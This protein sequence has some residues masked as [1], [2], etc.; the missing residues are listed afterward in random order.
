MKLDIDENLITYRSP[1]KPA[2]Q[3]VK[4]FGDRKKCPEAPALLL[5]TLRT[6]ARMTQADVAKAIGVERTSVV[7]MEA[8]NQVVR[9]E[10]LD[11]LADFLGVEL[12]LTIAPKKT[13]NADVTGLAPRKD[14]K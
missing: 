10:Y 1:I 11:K 9:F 2:P 7:N 13:P 3:R 8:L 5:R 4:N 6:T 12:V 14:D